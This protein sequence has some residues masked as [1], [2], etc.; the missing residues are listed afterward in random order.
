MKKELSRQR[1]QSHDQ[2]R[3]DHIGPQNP[4]HHIIAPYS[5]V[6]GAAVSNQIAAILLFYYSFVNMYIDARKYLR[7][8]HAGLRKMKERVPP[9]N[10]RSRARPVPT[11]CRTGAASGRLSGSSFLYLL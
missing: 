3:Y 10:Q 2:H 8:F 7:F 11:L 4:L 5:S 1:K 9:G 6:P